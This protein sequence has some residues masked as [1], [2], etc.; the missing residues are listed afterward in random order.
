MKK[1][2]LVVLVIITFI[3]SF[4]EYNLKKDLFSK[5]LAGVAFASGSY[6]FDEQIRNMTHDFGL[7][8][9]NIINTK[10]MV[11]TSA[12][13]YGSSFLF[14]NKD[15]SQISLK[16]LISSFVSGGAILTIKMIAGRAR[17]YTNEGKNSF[18]FLR[19]L[20]SDDYQ[21]FPSGHSGLS[22]A[23]TTPYAEEYSKWLYVIPTVIS[24]FRVIEDKHW[25]S[26][27]VIGSLIGYLTGKI[28]YEKSF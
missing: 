15:F 4:A 22:W 8:L 12:I 23:I 21:S 28:V 10:V 19:G 5:S 3:V 11:G 1:S 24:G 27:V 16:S 18:E 17:P 6:V 9:G 14:D 20:K 13:L 25:A 7:N 2:F 26:D